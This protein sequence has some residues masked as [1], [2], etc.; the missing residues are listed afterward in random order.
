[1]PPHPTFFPDSGS[2]CLYPTENFWMPWGSRLSVSPQPLVLL[3]KSPLGLL[4]CYLSQDLRSKRNNQKAMGSAGNGASPV[5]SELISVGRPCVWSLVKNIVRVAA[6]LWLCYLSLYPR[7]LQ[8]EVL[9]G[10]RSKRCGEWT[11]GCVQ[12]TH[13]SLSW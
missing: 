3:P 7:G 10:S 9:G 1:M 4:S 2:L 12:R 6:T 11:W 8:W 13:G 5:G